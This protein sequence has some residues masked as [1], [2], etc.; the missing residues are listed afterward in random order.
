[1][2]QMKNVTI[3]F[4]HLIYFHYFKDQAANKILIGVY[5][6]KSYVI[7]EWK[8]YV[9][10]ACKNLCK[11]LLHNCFSHYQHITSYI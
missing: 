4:K 1:M 10:K 8:R 3:L 6:T 2:R 7:Q 11:F 9:D 5:M